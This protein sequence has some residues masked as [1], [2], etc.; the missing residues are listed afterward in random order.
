MTK[1]AAQWA[2]GVV[3]VALLGVGVVRAV[4]AGSGTGNVTLLVVGAVLLLSPFFIDRIVGFSVSST[5]IEVRLTQEISSL[6]APGTAQILQRTALADFAE[7]YAYIR[8]ELAGTRFDDA[9]VYLQE[10]LVQRSAAIARR[11][12]FKAAEVRKLFKNGSPIMRVLALGL[13]H[14]DQSLA[15]G[16]TLTSAI[17]ES[18][19]ANEQ[20][21]GLELAAQCW[22]GLDAPD[23]RAIHQAVTNSGIPPGS[24]RRPLADAVLALPVSITQENK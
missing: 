12:K 22:R 17:A 24:D 4:Q 15:D 3:G 13:M 23:R 6:G 2:V 14:G 8:E 21:H 10:L 19:S 18:R 11:E 9:R 5:S 1:L 7:S 20:Y 16:P